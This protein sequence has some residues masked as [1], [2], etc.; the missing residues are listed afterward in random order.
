MVGPY[1]RALRRCELKSQ[2]S[3]FH[4]A[5]D[6]TPCERSAKRRYSAGRAP[7]HLPN[8]LSRSPDLDRFPPNKL[9]RDL[10]CTS[11]MARP[12][13]VSHVPFTDVMVRESWVPPYDGTSDPHTPLYCYSCVPTGKSLSLPTDLHVRFLL[14]SSMYDSCIRR[15]SVQLYTASSRK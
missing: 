10:E 11:G 13:P 9:Q 2:F 14:I 3:P 4:L 1:D 15:Y 6:V 5:T 8:W 12:A 7:C